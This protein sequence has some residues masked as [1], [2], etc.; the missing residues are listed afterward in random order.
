MASKNLRKIKKMG[1]NGFGFT[2]NFNPHNYTV[3][4]HRFEK[5]V[6]LMEK[7]ANFHAVFDQLFKRIWKEEVNKYLGLGHKFN[8]RLKKEMKTHVRQ[9]AKEMAKAQIANKAS[10][11]QSFKE[12]ETIL[13]EG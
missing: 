9:Q 1:L 7:R 6:G 10:A 5:Q 13:P 8:H 2:S 4:W 12:Q 11:Q 3:N